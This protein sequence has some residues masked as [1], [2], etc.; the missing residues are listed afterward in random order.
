MVQ[1]KSKPY[2]AEVQPVR[3]VVIVYKNPIHYSIWRYREYFLCD[4]QARRENTLQNY[5][6]H[7]HAAPSEFPSTIA[8]E[9]PSDCRHNTNQPFSIDWKNTSSEIETLISY[10]ACDDGITKDTFEIEYGQYIT[11]NRFMPAQNAIDSHCTIIVTW[12]PV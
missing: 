4:E 10:N 9:M 3:C 12:S 7:V 5:K 1:T 8:A 11:A 6:K 2:Y